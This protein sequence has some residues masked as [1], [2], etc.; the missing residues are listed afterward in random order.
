MSPRLPLT[1]RRRRRLL[2]YE[3]RHG[4]Q[5]RRLCH[6]VFASVLQPA[7]RPSAHTIR[8]QRKPK[9]I[10]LL[11]AVL[12]ID[13]QCLALWETNRDNQYSEAFFSVLSL[14]HL[15]FGACVGLL[16]GLPSEAEAQK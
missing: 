16:L 8:S 4:W 7:P 12:I 5:Q 15:L 3:S 13:F 10:N 11:T 2:N 1:D 9:L 6:S 14:T